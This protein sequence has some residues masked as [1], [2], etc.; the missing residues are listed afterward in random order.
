MTKKVLSIALLC[1]TFVAAPTVAAEPPSCDV[2]RQ[3]FAEAPSL[4]SLR[5]PNSR[6]FREPQDRFD[7]HDVWKTE[8]K[9]ADDGELRYTTGLYCYGSK[10][11]YV[12]ADIDPPNDPIHPTFD[13]I[14]ASIYAFTGWE[15]EK[16]VR[17]ANDVLTN[18]S[19]VIGEITNT[20]LWLG[21]YT[22]TDQVGFS[23]ILD[24][25]EGK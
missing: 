24:N 2:F 23:I 9:R 20:E 12:A 3:R 16:V 10:F 8:A 25:K 13:L 5:L 4:L 19:K 18:R 11:D 7:K 17:A 14:A 1:S 6:F 22:E 21:A 15:A